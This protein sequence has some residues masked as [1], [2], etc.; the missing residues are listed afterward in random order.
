M[1]ARQRKVTY[2]LSQALC[3]AVA[4]Y[5]H[6]GQRVVK[7]GDFDAANQTTH[8]LGNRE[9]MALALTPGQSFPGSDQADL[10][11]R[12]A[13]VMS[14]IEQRVMMNAL[15]GLRTPDFM[16]SLL[17][18]LQSSEVQAP[19]LGL[20][21]W[22][23]KMAADIVKADAKTETLGLLGIHSQHIG[24]LGQRVS[25]KFTPINSRFIREYNNHS[26]QGT[27]EAG[28]LVSFFFKKP[29]PADS[30]ITARVKAHVM[31]ERLSRAAVTRLH[32]V[33]MA[34]VD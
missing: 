28:N 2:D 31:D 12:A 24:I 9:L 32:F 22:A 5:D 33:K 4:A 29:I 14:V 3:L 27:D 7:R 8:D 23:P 13:E 15:A 20:L 16:N 6:M 26:H 30:V 17:V 11:E 1:S 34:K 19:E 21:A 25:L 10:A 18:L